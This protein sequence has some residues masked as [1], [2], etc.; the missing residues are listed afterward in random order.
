V[1]GIFKAEQLRLASKRGLVIVYDT[2]DRGEK[3]REVLR[4]YKPFAQRVRSF[5]NGE[6][7]NDVL[8]YPAK[9]GSLQG[10]AAP[11]SESTER[12]SG[13][14]KRQKISPTAASHSSDGVGDWGGAG[15]R[16]HLK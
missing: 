7:K 3:S 13:G 6:K 4:G 1:C 10:E 5:F 11:T 12:S 16:T 15:S 8:G 9:G 14:G 2:C